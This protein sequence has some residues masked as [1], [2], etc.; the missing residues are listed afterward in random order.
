MRKH[1]I[2]YIDGWLAH[3]DGLASDENPFDENKQKSS[4]YRWHRGWVDREMEIKYDGNL[5]LDKDW[6]DEND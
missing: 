1:S 5:A 2:Q 4:N 6:M 3:K